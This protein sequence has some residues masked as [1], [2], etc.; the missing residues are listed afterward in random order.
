M[1][2]PTGFVNTNPMACDNGL[3]GSFGNDS[4]LTGIVYFI[5]MN[6]NNLTLHIIV[7]FNVKQGNKNFE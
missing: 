1:S 7:T 6:I 5:K 4:Y 3:W 2:Q